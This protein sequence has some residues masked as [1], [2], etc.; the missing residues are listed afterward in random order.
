MLA[1]DNFYQQVYD[2]V[3]LIPKGRVTSYGAIAKALGAAKSSRMVG[4]A[5]IHA[6]HPNNKLPIYRVV[7][8]SGL[9]TGKHHYDGSEHMQQLLEA[10]GIE[11]EDDQIKDFK[12]LFWDPM[13]EL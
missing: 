10:E 5:L 12:K 7:N 13:I 8:R 11:I 4:R 2:I 3:A 9:L 1:K 6:H